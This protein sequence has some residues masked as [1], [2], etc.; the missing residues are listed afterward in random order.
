MAIT[1]VLGGIAG[2]ATAP[3][4]EKPEAH[5]IMWSSVGAA[6]AALYSIEKYDESEELDRLRLEVKKAKLTMSNTSL[7]SGGEDPVSTVQIS[8]GL[9]YSK[10]PPSIRENIKPTKMKVKKVDEWRLGSTPNSH[11]HCDTE[12]EFEGS[13]IVK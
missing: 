8:E 10:I 5:G 1:A 6:A 2:Y 9:P 11:L 4:G 12:V 13:R 3:D 7:T